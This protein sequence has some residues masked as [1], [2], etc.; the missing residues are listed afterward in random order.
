M[1]YLR[2][3]N[4]RGFIWQHGQRLDEE[5]IGLT[6]GAVYKAL[7]TEPEAAEHG[8]VRVIDNSAEDYLYPAHYFE[9]VDLHNGSIA[10]T[11]T[12][13][14]PDWMYGVL[15]AEAIAADKSISA[16]LRDLIAERFDLP[17]VA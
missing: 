7:P 4:N 17:E 1:T 10:K 14:L 3:I 9:P 5:I 13:H 6:V 11:A 2:C 8:M 15:Q 16:L 12:T